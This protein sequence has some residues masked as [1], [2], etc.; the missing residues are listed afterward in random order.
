[1]EQ[2]NNSTDDINIEQIM[3]DIRQQILDAKQGGRANF[4]VGGRRFSPTFYE[5]LYRAN[6]VQDTGGLKLDVSKSSIPIIGVLI[7]KLRE[8]FHNLVIFYLN[9]AVIPQREFNEHIFQA[10]TLLSQ[11]LE[12][13]IKPVDDL[14]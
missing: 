3:Q 11:E 13:E 8:K 1:M 2:Q 4:P 14:A 12:A 10:I 7:D 6:L 5:Q 9:Q